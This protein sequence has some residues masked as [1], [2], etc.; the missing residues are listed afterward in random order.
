LSP[1]HSAISRLDAYSLHATNDPKET[2]APRTLRSW[3][4]SS[5]K[6]DPDGVLPISGRERRAEYAKKACFARLAP[7]S[8]KARSSGPGMK[9]ATRSN[10]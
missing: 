5:E 9:A 4:A 8:A 1:D 10:L 7:K 3:R 6:S 2:T